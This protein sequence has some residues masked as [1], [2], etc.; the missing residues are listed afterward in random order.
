MKTRSFC[1]NCHWYPSGL[2]PVVITE[3]VRFA[4]RVMVLLSG[5]VVMPGG[6]VCALP[7]LPTMVKKINNILSPE[8]NNEEFLLFM[9]PP[10]YHRSH[11]RLPI[12]AETGVF[13]DK[14]RTEGTDGKKHSDAKDLDRNDLPR[15]LW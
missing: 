2:L 5:T 10:V 12:Y 1:S 11:N 4:P 7:A 6:T 9:F 3:S 13:S 14:R 15:A 8:A